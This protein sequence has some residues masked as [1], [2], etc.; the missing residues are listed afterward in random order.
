MSANPL[1]GSDAFL[2]QARRNNWQRYLESLDAKP[3]LH[4]PRGWDLCVLTASDRNQ[5]EMMR[6][7]LD[8]RRGRGLL[9]AATRFHV[10]ADPGGRRI[11]SGGATLRIL[12]ALSQPAERLAELDPD[13]DLLGLAEAATDRQ[14]TLIIHSGGDSR[15]L[16]HCSAVGKLFARIPHLLP[17]GRASTIFDE[18]LINL[19]GIAAAAPPGALVVS[20]DVMLVFDHLQLS[21]H[22]H[23]V[24]GVAIAAPAEL[25]LRHGVYVA[26]PGSK[27][28][29]AF[30]H[31][32]SRQELERW[33]AIDAAETVPID[34]GLAW[35]DASTA[36]QF[37]GLLS[38]P[39]VRDLAAGQAV[40]AAG[41][42]LY[43]D[44]LLPLA[45][46]TERLAYLGDESDGPA[47]PGLRAARQAI[48]TRLRGTPLTAERLEPAVFVHF[49]TSAEYWRMVAGD[50]ALAHLC[51]WSRHAGAWLAPAAQQAGDAFVLINAAL[52]APPAEP[53]PGGPQRP[54]LIADSRLPRLNWQG[55]SVVAGLLS[56][57]DLTLG[58]DLVLHQLP[59]TN[60]FVTRLFGL[61]DDP[62]RLWSDDK[63]TFLNRPFGDW[64]AELGESPEVLWPH[65]PQDQRNLWH[66]R[67]YPVTDDRDAS[68]E[69]ALPLQ[70]PAAASA[71]WRS[72]WKTAERLS[73]AEG[74]THAG[75]ARILDD[76]TAVEDA[77]AAEHASAAIRQERPA[78]EAARAL[79]T[80]D[81]AALARRCRLVEKRLE[82]GPQSLPWRGLAALA[83]ATGDA[84]YEDRAFANLAQ[85]IEADVNRRLGRASAALQ[86]VEA[87]HGAV[88]VAAPARVDFGGGWTDTPPYSIERGG[89]V[90]NAAVTLR[91]RRPIIAEASWLEEPALLLVSRDID[92]TLRPEVAGEVLDYRNPADP[93]ALVKAALVLKGVVPAGTDP[94][95]PLSTLLA[96]L[97]GGIQLATQTAIPRGSGLGTS[98]IMAGAVLTALDRLL[99]QADLA[100]E[101]DAEALFDQVL[102]LEQMMTTG[103]GWQ[104]QAG[105]LT[106]GV[107]LVT[108]RPGLPQQL[109][110]APLSPAAQD[111]LRRRLLLV[112]TGQQR[113]AKNLLRAVMGRWMARDPEMVWILGEIGR[114]AVAMRDALE[115]GD[116]D[117]FG[118]LLSEHWQ[119][120]KRMDPGCTNPF[121]D[122]LFT[123]LQPYISGGKLAG[124]GGGGFAI[125]VARHA[126]A[127]A[128]LAGALNRRY[129]QTPLALWEAAISAQ[130][131]SVD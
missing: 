115:A 43:G 109:R 25:G 22:R 78:E 9:P 2:Q 60:G 10:I 23:G 57:R 54:A 73:L 124:A 30:L 62:K 29:A 56:E 16:P 103:G 63:A 55:R 24:T 116:V 102:C 80:R 100:A 46:S 125:V 106:G 48:W 114:L 90:L 61:D 84:A 69:L 45:E 17:D 112:Y 111:A 82:E 79:T 4:A 3:G 72:R 33:G 28:V 117:G 110:L 121:I 105:G 39:A 19:S 98:S 89:I 92:E 21:F 59:V 40:G 13:S 87:A 86:P 49:G 94:A 27:N 18:M 51:G 91:G 68:L 47:T 104:D 129:A 58:A 26:S 70:A 113:L 131:V 107:K 127:T 122:D 44:L 74:F 96:G 42:N 52:D 35:F 8:W 6:R 41:I 130:G 38:E 37:A 14:R 75:G 34:T 95:A 118:A 83:A 7:Q 71:A 67:L 20:G 99:G 128:E 50:T 123:F 1:R 32:A 15:R 12:A 93:F 36:A 53:V 126:Q 101:S 108:S 85:A 31:K 5:A 65:V 88:R 77:I 119:L 97:P 64:L 120:N 81:P 76:I 11:G 66:A